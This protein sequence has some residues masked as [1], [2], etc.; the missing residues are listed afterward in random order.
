MNAWYM[1]W[2]SIAVGGRLVLSTKPA[3]GNDDD[4]DDDCDNHKS[5]RYERG[6]WYKGGEYRTHTRTFRVTPYYQYGYVA[7]RERVYVYSDEDLT[8]PENAWWHD[9]EELSARRRVGPA[10]FEVHGYVEPSHIQFS[11]TIERISTLSSNQWSSPQLVIFVNRGGPNLER[12]VLGPAH[13]LRRFDIRPGDQ[14]S[15]SGRSRTI[16]GSPM[17]VANRFSTREIRWTGPAPVAVMGAGRWFYGEVMDEE[18]EHIDDV[19]HQ[20]VRM[21]LDDGQRVL[22]DLGPTRYLPDLDFD[23]GD[24]IVVFGRWGWIEDT[25]GVIAD[26]FRFEG[27]SYVLRRPAGDLD[28]EVYAYYP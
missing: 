13:E 27:D 16:D 6:D 14:I 22:V 18:T 11:G 26:E 4:D 5:A 9:Y 24:D 3:R 19:N 2:F 21:R 10:E 28:L 8:T 7:P 20:L 1:K 23:R 17:V 25:T 12:V 15:V